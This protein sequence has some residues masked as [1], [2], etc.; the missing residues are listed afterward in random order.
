MTAVDS[1]TRAIQQRVGSLRAA[2]AG[3]DSRDKAITFLHDVHALVGE[4]EHLL[5]EAAR[6]A[7]AAGCTWQDVGDVVGTTRQAAFQ[8]F[9]KPIDP[10]T[11]A[12]MA[13]TALPDATQKANSLFSLFPAHDWAGIFSTFTPPV[14]ARLPQDSLPDIWAHVVAQFGE[15]ESIGDEAYVRTQG[16][17]TVV[18]LPI[19]FE[20]GAMVGR[21]SYDQQGLVAGLF[22][23]NPEAVAAERDAAVPTRQG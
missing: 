7:R 17:H 21:V 15:L 8:R 14:A 12:P 16:I 22:F 3:L 1:A 9:G 13:V 19:E 20:A 6:A 23:L 10:R 2:A 11:G 5:G 18:D 4:S